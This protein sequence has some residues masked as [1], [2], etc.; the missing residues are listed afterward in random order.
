MKAR[1]TLGAAVAL[2]GGIAI[3]VAASEP[4]A[5]PALYSGKD[6]REAALALLSVAEGQAG[7]GSWENIGVARVYYLMG[8]REKAQAMLD[9]V[10]AGKMKAN[11]WVRVA[12]LYAEA[13]EWEKVRDA[14][15]KTLAL[16]PK[17][18][19]Y[20]AEAGCQYNL[21]GDRARAEELFARSLELD[22]NDV[23]N[24]ANIAGSYVGVRPQ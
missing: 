3:V 24:T 18:A 20:A 7:K 10:M 8:E 1:H 9:R 2:C 5:V 11:D 13:G 16:D 6:A 14:L 12:R 4:R 17:D 22:D 21:N 19:D 15:E 23:W